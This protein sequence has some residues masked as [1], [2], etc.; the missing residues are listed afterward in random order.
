MTV[1]EQ[2]AEEHYDALRTGRCH[3]CGALYRGRTLTH[4]VDCSLAAALARHEAEPD[5]RPQLIALLKA[6][7]DMRLTERDLSSTFRCAARRAFHAAIDA[8]ADITA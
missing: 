7:Q 1:R 5:D 6:A 4:D 3:N 2:L 8:C